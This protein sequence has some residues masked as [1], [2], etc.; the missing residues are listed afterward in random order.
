MFFT[1]L[2]VYLCISITNQASADAIL[3]D[4]FETFLT[5]VSDPTAA[6]NPNAPTSEYLAA[7]VDRLIH[8]PPRLWNDERRSSLQYALQVR[9]S[10]SSNVI[11]YAVGAA[12]F[13]VARL[14]SPRPLI[15]ILQ[16]QGPRATDSAEACK[17]LLSQVDTSAITPLAVADALLYMAI[18][19]AK[20]K[21]DLLT[22]VNALRQHRHGHMLD[23]QH[24]ISAFD[25]PDLRVTKPQFLALYNALVSIAKDGSAFDIQALWGGSTSLQ[26][27][28]LWAD[29]Q[30]QLS[31]VVA[32]L[33]S[34]P[35]ELDVSQI[36]NLRTAFSAAEFETCT[37]DVQEYAA[38]AATHPLVSR[39]AT[40]ALFTIIFSSQEA[41]NAAQRLGIP[42][43]VINANT[44]IFVCA[45]SAVPKPWAPLQ[46]QALK[47]LF[48]PFFMK[49]LPNHGFVLNAL[50]VHDKQWLAGRLIEYYNTNQTLLTSI[51]EHA[52]DNGWSEALTGVRNDFGLDFTALAFEMDLVNLEKWASDHI[53][54]D[55]VPAVELSR[56]II[57]F[58]RF[59][60]DD[61]LLVQREHHAPA[62]VALKVK[63]V[64]ALLNII[65]GT[66]SEQEE[67]AIQRQCIQAYPRLINYGYKFDA[68][69]DTNG[70]SGNALSEAADTK[71]QECYK[72]MYGHVT[73]AREM[74]STLRDLKNSENPEDQEFFASM[75]SGLFEEYNCFGEYPLEALAATAV[76]FG[77]I[78]NYGILH[79]RIT[80][81][82]AL[83]MVV[84]AVNGFSPEDSM[85]K[86]GLQ[87]ML[88]F[89]KRLDEWPQLCERL[90]RMAGLR[91]TEVH[92]QVE[93]VL[94]EQ[95]HDQLNGAIA[96]AAQT[97]GPTD[98]VTE[99]AYQ[100]FSSVRPDPAPATQHY[101]TPAEGTSDK[102]M[103]VLNN[104]SKRNLDEK[105]KEL[106]SALEERHHQWFAQYLVGD[107][108]KVQPNFQA[109][110]L[111]ILDLF[112]FKSLHVE[113]LRETYEC[114]QRIINAETTATN[115]TDRN[116]LKNLAGWL[117]LITLA[118]NL[119]ILHRNI[120]FK[121][122]LVEA[123]QTERLAIA[124][125]FTCKVLTQA[126]QST[127]FKPPNPWTM[128]L[129]SIL[130]ELYHFAEIK[131]NMKFEI[132]VLCKELGI[133][134]KSVEPAEVIRAIPTAAEE[135]Y[136]QQYPNESVDG[137]GDMLGLT[138]R[139]NDRISAA[140]IM[141]TLPD[142]SD[143]LIL[144]PA[145][146][147]VNQQTLK[148]VFLTAARQAIQEIIGP[149]AERSV[150]IA[151]IS[152]FQLVEKDFALE[153][154]TEKMQQAAYTMVKALSGS[155]ALVTCK[156]PLRM[157]MSNNVRLLASEH[158]PDQLPEGSILMFLNDN[159]D[160]VCKLV[161]DAA[162]TYSIAEIDA[163]L[164]QAVEARR[165]YIQQRSHQG[166]QNPEV[167]KWAFAIPEPYRQNHKG[168][169]SQQLVIYEDFG[170]YAKAAPPTHL[171]QSN[172]TARQLPDVLGEN[173]LA[174]PPSY[175]DN[176]GLQQRLQQGR[177]QTPPAM[178][179]PNQGQRPI[180]GYS[181]GSPNLVDRVHKLV[182]EIQRFAREQPDARIR[183][184]EL[185]APLR[186]VF[187]QLCQVV[188]TCIQKDDLALVAGQHT[189]TVLYND[190]K[191]RLETEM[192]VQFLAHLCQI[193]SPTAR[194][195]VMYLTGFEDEK[196]L[197]APA[198]ISLLKVMLLDKHHVDAN[199]AR[200]IAQRRADVVEFMAIIVEE[201]LT[202]EQTNFYRANFVLALGELSQ[203]SNDEPDN[204][205]IREILDKI[206]QPM[207]DGNMSPASVSQT[208]HEQIAY[209]L[210]EWV[211]LQ[212][213]DVP[214]RALVA[215]INQLHSS[216]VI[217]NHD[218]LATMLRTCI[219]LSVLAYDREEEMSYG[220]LDHAYI[221]VD[222]VAKLVAYLVGYQEATQ[223]NEP[224]AVQ[225]GK[226]KYL[227]HILCFIV[228]VTNHHY[229]SRGERFN[230][231]LFYR[232]FSTLF[233][234][235][236]TL[237]AVLGETMVEIPVVL[238]QCL[239][240]LQ[241]QIFAGFSFAWLAL[242]SHRIFLSMVMRYADDRVSPHSLRQGVLGLMSAQGRQ[243]FVDLLCT[244][245]MHLD[246]LSRS[247]A[248]TTIIQDYYRG[249]LRILCMLQHDFPD[250]IAENFLKL[251][252]SISVTMVQLHNVINCANSTTLE[253]LP[254]PFTPGLKVTR[255]EQIRHIPTP[256]NGD[257]E[258]LLVKAGIKDAVD[259][260]RSG[261]DV[262]IESSKAILLA[263]D[264]PRAAVSHAY[265]TT[266]ARAYLINA[267]IAYLAKA[268]TA[269]HQMAFP[270]YTSSEKF[271]VALLEQAQPELR[272]QLIFAMANQVRF[273]NAFTYYYST[274]F[275]H[276]FTV[277]SDE[278]QQTLARVLVERLMVAH[279]HPWG[280][281]VTVLELIKN[282]KP[283]N[284]FEQK[285]MKAAPEIEKMLLSIL[286]TQDLRANAGR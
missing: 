186:T 216:R 72:E 265:P 285:W 283:Y 124:I 276:L 87:A 19:I 154:D 34:G 94:R 218:D 79:S 133:D 164:E 78:I 195:L 45:A 54:N 245:F 239:L 47:Q 188:E 204:E 217:S 184:L 38:R 274:A 21:Y 37:P 121:D 17:T 226:I 250:F 90:S 115:P 85:Y 119:P 98:V 190:C 187:D 101:E 96:S 249:S 286:Q 137:F 93:Q 86:F 162:E 76:L 116:N 120:S 170:R 69:I 248:Q 60:A 235:L 231:R 80:L 192:F 92:A 41:Y 66:V 57:N 275:M 246:E 273:P 178:Q 153:A 161:E 242:I 222:G 148:T 193:S 212:R 260:Q 136:L 176:G 42:E 181:N 62:T 140:E 63:T 171:S 108:V 33:S 180:N 277:T 219:D 2:P 39:D 55:G 130:I 20:G 284:I 27:S 32:F 206:N 247:S 102:V 61:E 117:G 262:S 198:T 263:L 279:P 160:A 118:R 53:Q 159:L 227:E 29:P 146:G 111:Q 264:E 165:R 215:F 112:N 125:P 56:A 70:A 158:L 155:L 223:G 209:L 135:S 58:L 139:A 220:S 132:E 5:A 82:V 81:S 3:S 7:I 46:E 254:D 278:V 225:D 144:P 182:V 109:L 23:W 43:A 194:Q 25:R 51:F 106:S 9:Y 13:N 268:D 230:S 67:S 74:I 179:P 142:L 100:P 185:G 234:E 236:N 157:A 145:P 175:G 167:S 12:L 267:L 202:S 6:E 35:D 65:Q 196:L 221:N 168:L 214:E 49:A 59:K 203:W 243:V 258:D 123:H 88:H 266:S 200:M 280:L 84:D 152:T 83:A 14:S 95:G 191:C 251:N 210:E 24:V 208:K 75:I 150:T 183:D 138:K 205:Q 256:E 91:G 228:L 166:F 77:G 147:S 211:L 240:T 233:I 224:S 143:L 282:N 113:V 18:T 252:S 253:E 16:E 128:E 237:R 129:I 271:L 48:S 31:F 177:M 173:Y 207:A 174:N 110:Y 30:T 126:S 107:L 8:D 281:I 259:R 213:S 169:N 127:I 257:V 71:M 50:W 73:D 255:L 229:Q 141:E 36:P 28:A 261:K 1:A 269:D 105:F 52:Q 10:R 238:G 270:S 199:I 99:A 189:T 68:I 197:N 122:L 103:F 163:H 232:F 40:N 104:V 241:P 26:E 272:Y 172:D 151:A 44:D 97:E 134:H 156:E 89:M 22:F 149:V 244:L 15:N 4:A 201:L 114:I 64:Y 11:P 131:L